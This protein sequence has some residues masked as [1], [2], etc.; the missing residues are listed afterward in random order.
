MVIWQKELFFLFMLKSLKSLWVL[1][2]DWAANQP[3]YFVV[4]LSPIVVRTSSALH[5]FPETSLMFSYQ[6]QK[7]KHLLYSCKVGRDRTV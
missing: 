3:R 5:A 4:I 6:Q 7:C 1:C 2:F